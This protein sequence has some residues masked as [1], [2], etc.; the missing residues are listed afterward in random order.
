MDMPFTS[1]ATA[2]PEDWRR[3]MAEERTMPYGTRAAGLLMMMLKQ[4]R[5]DDAFGLPV[6]TYQHCLQT[7][8]CVAN[9][10]ESPELIVCSLFHDVPEK[11]APFSHGAVIADILAPFISERNEWMLRHHP[12]FQQY[13]FV[14]R[15][16]L[17]RDARDAFRGSPHFTYAARYCEIYD[18]NSFDPGFAALPL[19]HFEAIVETYFRRFDSLDSLRIAP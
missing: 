4:Q 18:Q 1:L 12:A 15:P 19:A 8:T 5:D 17:N 10:G 6:N 14:E 7:A 16:G 3:I 11:M 9:A 2:S 13:H